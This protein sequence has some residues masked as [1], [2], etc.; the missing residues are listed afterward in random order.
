MTHK[1]VPSKGWKSI[2]WKTPALLSSREANTKAAM[3]SCKA[4]IST[5]FLTVY[6]QKHATAKC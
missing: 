1:N 4:V 6:A 2:Y 3:V 5:K